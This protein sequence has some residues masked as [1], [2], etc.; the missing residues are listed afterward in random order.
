MIQFHA[1]PVSILT[2][3]EDLADQMVEHL[4]EEFVHIWGFVQVSEPEPVRH[5]EKKK[6]KK[7]KG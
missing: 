4:S 1:D 3:G 7:G 6:G 5:P 2:I